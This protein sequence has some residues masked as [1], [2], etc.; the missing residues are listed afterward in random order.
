MMSQIKEQVNEN[1]PQ[2]TSNKYLRGLFH[3]SY[4]QKYITVRLQLIIHL[5]HFLLIQWEAK[6]FYHIFTTCDIAFS[7]ANSMLPL[8]FIHC[9][10]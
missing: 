3:N 6:D 7:N 9:I 2:S 5:L 10:Y 8:N 1:S 4:E